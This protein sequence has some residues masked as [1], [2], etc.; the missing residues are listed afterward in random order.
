VVGTTQHELP[1]ERT[2]KVVV[3]VMEIGKGFVAAILLRHQ[4]QPQNML[5]KSPCLQRMYLLI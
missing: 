4:N 2:T 1:V 3:F 5:A